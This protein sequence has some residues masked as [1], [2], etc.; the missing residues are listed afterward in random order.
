MGAGWT[1]VYV[2]AGLKRGYTDNN[3]MAEFENVPVGTAIVAASKAGYLA[4]S[5]IA[6]ADVRLRLGRRDAQ[7]QTSDY[8]NGL[9][10]RP[11]EHLSRH[12][13]YN[14]RRRPSKKLIL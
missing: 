12:R 7:S 1:D 4:Q 2:N 10:Q 3:G 11:L 14:I 5:K 13:H 8:R 6:K 9:Y